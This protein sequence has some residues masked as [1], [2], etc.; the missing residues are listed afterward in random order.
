MIWHGY[1]YCLYKF[2]VQES[3]AKNMVVV[4]RKEQAAT[5]GTLRLFHAGDAMQ[6]TVVDTVAPWSYPPYGGMV[7]DYSTAKSFAEKQWQEGRSVPMPTTQ[8]AYGTLT[9]FTEPIL[10]RRAMVVTD[11]YVVLADYLRG[12][13]EHTFE[14]LMQVKGYQGLDGVTQVRHDAQW[15]SDPLSSAQF[16]TDANWYAGTSPITARFET[17]FGPEGDP[18]G[19]RPGT[20]EPGVLKLDVHSLWPRQQQVM[21]AQ[22]PEDQGVDKRLFWTVRGDGRVLAE[23]KLG[24]WILGKGEVDVSLEDVESLELET[25]VEV[26]KK[27]SLFWANAVV[28]TRDGKEVPLASLPM[29]T[30]NVTT[31]RGVDQDYAGGPI[32]IGGDP[33]SNAFA[34][35]PKDTGGPAVIRFDMHGVGALR[36]KAIVGADFPSGDEGQRRKTLAVQSIGREARFLSVIEPY[37]DR[38]MVKRVVA[39]DENTIRVELN[40]GRT[41]EITFGHLDGSGDDVSVR[42]VETRGGEAGRDESARRR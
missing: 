15:T 30:E 10:Q 18:M 27:P 1:G 23:G 38:T 26:A 33:V 9:D 28:V 32:K 4:D 11:D 37:E 22:T 40:D 13:R 14:S 17:K 8:P 7:Y 12:E 29:T 41:Q 19:F 39:V 34:A 31:S 16:V 2:Y 24:A 3:V 21:V 20:Q 35:E 42:L 5:P 36:L 6:A 25:R